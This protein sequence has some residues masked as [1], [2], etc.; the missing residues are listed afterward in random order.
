MGVALTGV[1]V[2]AAATITFGISVVTFSAAVIFA[3]SVMV[4]TIGIVVG[5][6]FIA[7]SV[8]ITGCKKFDAE[9]SNTAAAIATPIISRSCFVVES[10]LISQAAS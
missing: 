6:I 1:A 5:T 9:T 8:G 10:S 7:S 3:G 4:C 2:V